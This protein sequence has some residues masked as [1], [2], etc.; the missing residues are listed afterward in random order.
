MLPMRAQF[1]S[2]TALDV[3]GDS[4]WVLLKPLRYFSVVAD[5]QIDVPA[6]FITDMA[7]IPRF[8]RRVIP[9]NG[10]HR[11]PAIVHDWIY[12]NHG[13]EGPVSAIP[14]DLAD[15]VFSEG[16]GV[17]GVPAWKRR[18]MYA[19]VRTGGGRYWKRRAGL[20]PGDDIIDIDAG[21]DWLKLVNVA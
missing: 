1:L 9:V 12:A 2:R 6:G 10:R 19:A 13:G 14:R 20:V 18:A 4:D 7:S 15:A 11:Y 8:F 17:V 16:M 21:I 5:C 3:W